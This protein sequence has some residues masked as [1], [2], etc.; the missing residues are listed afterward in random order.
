[1][2]R[3]T[4][5]LIPFGNEAEKETIG[6]LEISNGGE[7]FDGLHLYNCAFAYR[8]MDG[9]AHEGALQ[10]LHE[11]KRNVMRLLGTVLDQLN[12]RM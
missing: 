7:L 10:V 4:I 5:D 11:R 12:W 6:T 8:D 9:A 1:M 2:I 3:V